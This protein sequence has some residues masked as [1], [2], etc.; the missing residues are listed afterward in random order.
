MNNR[1]MTPEEV[2]SDFHISIRNQHRLRQEKLI[3]Y[4]KVGRLV[5]YDRNELDK[6]LEQNC[7]VTL[8]TASERKP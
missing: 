4:S 6:W 8:A 2:L 5:R 7:I 1:W 3:P